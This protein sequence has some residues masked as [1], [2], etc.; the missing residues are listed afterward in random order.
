MLIEQVQTTAQLLVL[1]LKYL[2][3]NKIRPS[4]SHRAKQNY[5]RILMEPSMQREGI[6]FKKIQ[7]RETEKVNFL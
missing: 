6:L 2:R 5:E 1:N 3:Q 4:F 7:N